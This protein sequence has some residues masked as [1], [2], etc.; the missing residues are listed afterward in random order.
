MNHI[1]LFKQ[2]VVFLFVWY[3]GLKP[4]S[5]ASALGVPLGKHECDVFAIWN[6]L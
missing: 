1:V 3:F 6:G 5:A 4:G 2:K